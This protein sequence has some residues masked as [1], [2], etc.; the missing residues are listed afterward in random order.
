MNA[1]DSSFAVAPARA[2]HR[3]LAIIT[4]FDELCGIAAYAR[5]LI[6]Q[7][8]PVFDLEVFEL[9]QFLLRGSSKR[10]RRSADKHIESIASALKNFDCV[11]IQ[12]EYGTLGLGAGDIVRRFGRLVDAASAIS[13]T[14]HTVI[15]PEAAF[16]QAMT[17]LG[18][19]RVGKAAGSIATYL[20]K[21]RLL[22]GTFLPLQRSQHKK[23]TSVIVHTQ[24]DRNYVHHL[25][26]I[27]RVYEHPLAF[28]SA[29]EAAEINAKASRRHFP[30]LDGVPQDA[31]LVG[32][33]GFISP[34]KGL[35]TVIRA[36]RHLPPDHHLL[37]FGA[38]HPQEIRMWEPIDPFLK[39][40]LKEANVGQSILDQIKE[41]AGEGLE[42]RSVSFSVDSSTRGIFENPSPHPRDLSGRVHFMGSLDDDQF[43]LGMAICDAVV[44]PYLEVGQSSS[45]PISNAVELGCR[46]IASR[47]SAFR[48]FGR[49]HP[50]LVEYFDIGNH[51]ELAQRI[52]APSPAVNHRR[53]NLRFDTTTNTA[54]YLR[55]NSDERE[56]KVVSPGVERRP[57]A[58]TAATAALASVDASL[59]RT[60]SGRELV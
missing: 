24:R 48:Q 58:E 3:R 10:L 16:N 39:S 2:R 49:Y 35:D 52:K 34:Y 32:T 14:C 13:V 59:G 33:F 30:V 11:N 18:G 60:I 22:R 40:L 38:V 29:K 27:E 19:F 26:G 7:L 15:R 21:R 54:I 8:E 9:D 56:S 17:D 46:V 4:S 50:N 5:A 6:R 37:I 28:I 12:L 55:A 41:M 42:S 43:A 1:P 47:T 51:L 31:K 53:A 57:G 23:P 44:L 45:G 20:E 36:I 25:C